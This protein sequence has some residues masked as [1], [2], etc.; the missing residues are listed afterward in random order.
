VTTTGCDPARR[1]ARHYLAV[2]PAAP[3]APFVERLWVHDVSGPEPE[4]LRIL[5]DGRMDLVWTRELGAHVSGPRSSF[6]T[7]AEP[8]RAYGVRFR[9]GAAPS[10]LRVPA[11]ELLD[12]RLPLAALD[13]R[14]GRRLGDRLEGARDDREA[15]AALDAELLR[16]LDRSARPDP[17]VREAVAL[18][19]DP[20][21]PI[22]T[23]AG[24]LFVSERLLQRRFADA[25]GYG[26]K[27]LQRILRFQRV[28]AALR[29]PLDLAA[30]AKAAGYADQA[31]LSRE[32]RRLAG[33]SPRQ[34][35]HWIA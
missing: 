27:T 10:L 7:H 9:P 21:T 26:P 34:L 33:L 22:A 3:L 13:A 8:P 20:A 5:P 31:H 28:I 32:S 4:E 16:W 15:F 25:I 23:I 11:S 29:A 24:R 18:L 17:V 2:P 14:A 6:R 35:A 12:E 19:A 1:E 30:T